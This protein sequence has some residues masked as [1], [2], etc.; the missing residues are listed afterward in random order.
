MLTIKRIFG[1]SLSELEGLLQASYKG[2]FD[3]DDEIEYFESI[4]PPYWFYAL[5][6]NGLPRGFIRYFPIDDKLQSGEIYKLV[7]IARPFLGRFKVFPPT[8]ALSL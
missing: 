3:L 8:S 7:E 2:D 1:D 6:V 5:N 4:E